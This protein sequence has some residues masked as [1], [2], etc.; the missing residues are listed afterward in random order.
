[1]AATTSKATRTLTDEN[2]QREV[3]DAQ[4]P[5][6]VDVWA[7]WCGPCRLVGPVIDE[8]AEQFA[9]RAVVGKLDADA[10]PQTAASLKVS[11]LPTVLVYRDGEVIDRIIGVQSKDR[12]AG[13]LQKALG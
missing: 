11:A 10:N 9:G 13:A 2:F 4:Q 12:Y 3:E 1:M 6:L 7:E 8:V 5:V